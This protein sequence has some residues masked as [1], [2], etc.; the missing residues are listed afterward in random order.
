MDIDI[1]DPSPDWT[2]LF[3]DDDKENEEEEEEEEEEEPLDEERVNPGADGPLGWEEEYHV[4]APSHANSGDDA[5]DDV[6]EAY[7]VSGTGYDSIGAS[8]SWTL[9]GA[10]ARG[11]RRTLPWRAIDR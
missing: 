4:P 7:R 6:D 10:R 3:P 8:S 2:S 11:R 9:G 5:V 1:D